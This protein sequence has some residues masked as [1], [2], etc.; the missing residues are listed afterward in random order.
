MLN[1]ADKMLDS[2]CACTFRA[3]VT[4]IYLCATQMGNRNQ[5]LVLYKSS[6]LFS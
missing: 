3:L 2:E 1:C 6:K 5:V 4:D